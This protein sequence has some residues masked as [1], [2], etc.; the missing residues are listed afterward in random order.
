MGPPSEAIEACKGKTEGTE[1]EFT[2][3]RGDKVK[4]TCRMMPVPE[5]F[6][7]DEGPRGMKGRMAQELGLS[8]SQKKQINALLKA[9][10]EKSAPLREQIEENRE[11]LRKASLTAP[12]NEAAVRELA[13]KQAQLKTELL[14][15]HARVKS[16]ISALLTPEQRARAEKLRPPMGPRPGQH[17]P[18]FGWDD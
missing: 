2:T 1:V 16:E 5:G 4:A 15:S 12:F 17:M 11:Q 10:Q 13:A 6:A 9:E 18:H 8:E 3:R 14:V 7:G